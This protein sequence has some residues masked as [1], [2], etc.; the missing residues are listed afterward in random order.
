MTTD[1]TKGKIFGKLTLFLL[2][3]LIGN[4]F[5]QLYSMVDT[6]IVGRTISTNALAGVGA[7]GPISFLILGFVQGLTAGFAVRTS[8]FFG[9]QKEDQ[10]R[11]SVASSLLLCLIL[12]IFL[13]AIS[14]LTARPLLELMRTPSTIIEDSWQ[15]IIAIYWGLAA[16]VFYNMVSNILR[17][18]GDSRTPLYFLILASLINIG[19]DFL[20][21]LCFRMGV[22]GAGWA[23]V[24]SQALAGLACLIY[25][26]RKFPSLRLR[27]SDFSTNFQ[28]CWGHLVIGLPMAFQFSITAIG[29]MAQQT[30]LNDIGD[31][32]VAAY[33][34]ASKIDQLATQPVNALGTAMA[35]FTGQNYGAGR[36]DRIRKGVRAGFLIGGIC[37]LCTGAIVILLARS[38]VGLFMNDVTP[39]IEDYAFQFLFWQGT[40]YLA[41]M[42]IFLYRNTLQGMGY[43]P[44][45]MLAG[46]TELVMRV[47]AAFILAKLYGFLGVCLS[48]PAAW[49]GADLFLIPTFYLLIRKKGRSPGPDVAAEEQNLP[50]DGKTA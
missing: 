24:L 10:V 44:L 21:I 1:F 20:F 7:T 6:I 15:Y 17:A 16:T 8:Q 9:A 4:V 41:L 26:F 46:V 33:T 50:G 47:L 2:P 48:N 14:V 32:A 39:Q 35:T 34:A 11:K 27:R 22:A 29:V 38:T 36:Y 43:S 18:V 45:T 25:M 19:L 49:V 31:T 23:T 3:I 40:F 42:W 28:F 12:T 30:A 5:Q 37:A 13:T